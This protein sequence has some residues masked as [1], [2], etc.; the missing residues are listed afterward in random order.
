M[1]L[2]AGG[3]ADKLGNRYEANWIAYLL[4]EL[5]EEK[6]QSI[7]IEPIGDDEVGVDVT[8][9]RVDGRIEHHQCKVS[10]SND[11]FWSFARLK[12][13]GILEKSLYQLRRG[14]NEFR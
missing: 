7:T 2:E 9:E 3:Y 13:A 12:S 4:L 14:T 10:N 5:L 11:E 1:S 6:A 8:V